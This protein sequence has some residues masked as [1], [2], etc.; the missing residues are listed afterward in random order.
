MR[1]TVE[2]D[3]D[4][5]A[6]VKKLRTEEGLGTSD[7]VNELVRRGMVPRAPRTAFT[8]TTRP[9]G[10]RIDLSNIGDVLETLEGVEHR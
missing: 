6:A 7:A 9:M 4:T 1:T 10:A 3:A 8:Q 5:A 2:F